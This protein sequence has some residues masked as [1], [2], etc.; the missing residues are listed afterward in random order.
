MFEAKCKAQTINLPRVIRSDS[1]T[2]SNQTKLK[3]LR[4]S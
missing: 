4:S 3:M 1:L 2:S